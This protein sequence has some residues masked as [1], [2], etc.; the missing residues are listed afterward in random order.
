GYGQ[1]DEQG[2]CRSPLPDQYDGPPAVYLKKALQA[3]KMVMW[4]CFRNL[5]K[6]EQP[7][8]LTP[9]NQILQAKNRH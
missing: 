4:R 8:G 1:H 7:F 6:C 3:D 2:A 9:A 5:K